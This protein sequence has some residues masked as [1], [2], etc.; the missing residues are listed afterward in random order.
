MVGTTR[1]LMMLHKFNLRNTRFVFAET[2]E[3]RYI[4]HDTREN[5]DRMEQK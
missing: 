1:E 2:L 4:K 3:P 5:S